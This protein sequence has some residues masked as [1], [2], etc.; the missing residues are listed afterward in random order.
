MNEK[1]IEHLLQ[2]SREE[3]ED[4]MLWDVLLEQAHQGISMNELHVVLSNPTRIGFSDSRSLGLGGFTQGGRGWRLKLNSALVAH[5]HDVA[6]NV[7]EFLGMAITLWLSPIECE[8]MGL[9]NELLLILGDNTSAKSWIIRS[10]LSKSSVYRPV[11]LFNARQ[12]ASKVSKS[13]KFIVPQH[14]PGNMNS[15][16]DW[17]SF[18]GGNV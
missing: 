17:L 3:R 1:N 4:A 18:E 12:V 10:S 14:L 6:N 11:V 9:I 8:D 16:A 5:G 13:H 15:I 2:L 7:L